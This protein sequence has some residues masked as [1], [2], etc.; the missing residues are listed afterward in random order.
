MS[1]FFL[2]LAAVMLGLF[3]SGVMLR[4]VFVGFTRRQPKEFLTGLLGGLDSHSRVEL[5]Q[6]LT[7][8]GARTADVV[9]PA[10]RTEAERCALAQ[11]QRT[12]NLPR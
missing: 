8:C 2:V 6:Q 3:L 4:S 5:M 9:V 12:G 10:L 1:T 7:A 11:Y